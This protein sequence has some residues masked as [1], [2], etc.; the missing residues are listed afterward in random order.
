MMST[1]YNF[2][3]FSNDHING[4]PFSYHYYYIL[5]HHQPNQSVRLWRFLTDQAL[6]PHLR[7]AINESI[8]K[9]VVRPINESF[10]NDYKK[11]SMIPDN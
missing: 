4:Y 11:K 6:H 3:C 1:N 7:H 2:I 10:F 5:Y 8:E 9:Q